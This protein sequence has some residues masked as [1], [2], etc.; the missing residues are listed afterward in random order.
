MRVAILMLSRSAFAALNLTY[1]GVNLIMFSRAAFAALN[2]TY[3]G[4]N[5]IMFRCALVT[6]NAAYARG[7]F[8]IASE[9]STEKG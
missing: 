4:G 5:L 6:V 9:I 2:L 1:M 8:F 7:N 3:L